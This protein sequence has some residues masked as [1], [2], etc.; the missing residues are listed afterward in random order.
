MSTKSFIS[1][2]IGQTQGESLDL[3]NGLDST[4]CGLW[5]P[6]QA[7]N[8]VSSSAIYRVSWVGTRLVIGTR[9]RGASSRFMYSPWN[10]RVD[11]PLCSILLV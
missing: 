4:S 6:A 10:Q 2:N 3:D 11:G 1:R 5:E 7:T 8:E 9:C